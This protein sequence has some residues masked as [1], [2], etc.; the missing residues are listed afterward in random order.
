MIN[1]LPYGPHILV[2]SN[3]RVPNF[4]IWHN[5]AGHVNTAQIRLVGNWLAAHKKAVSDGSETHL[6][7]CI[8][9]DDIRVNNEPDPYVEKVALTNYKYAVVDFMIQW[10]DKSTET[11]REMF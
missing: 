11:Y 3:S 9:L 2:S 10:M 1:N 7:K 4:I 6:L 5:P 8:K